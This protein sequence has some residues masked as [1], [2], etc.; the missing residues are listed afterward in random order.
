MSAEH[1]QVEKAPK[2]RGGPDGYGL[3]FMQVLLAL[4]RQKMCGYARGRRASH[5]ETIKLRNVPKKPNPSLLNVPK[6]PLFWKIFRY[7][8]T[9]I[10]KFPKIWSKSPISPPF[11]HWLPPFFI[12]AVAALR[13][14]S[15]SDSFKCHVSFAR[16][17][18]HLI[19]VRTFFFPL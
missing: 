2:K 1:K 14:P 15:F 16:R 11:V 7:N 19:D 9:W 3:L 12:T 18:S 5:G 6:T 8:L 13:C 10:C 4:L 17:T